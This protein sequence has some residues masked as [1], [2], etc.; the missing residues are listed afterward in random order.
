MRDGGWVIDPTVNKKVSDMA[1]EH[2]QIFASAFEGFCGAGYQPLMHIGQQ[3]VQGMNHAYIALQTIS[4][5]TGTKTA[6]V[7]VTLYVPLN[8]TPVISSIEA[9]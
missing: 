8:A 3:V 7:K 2:Y 5:P 1:P 6:V 9:I 4:L